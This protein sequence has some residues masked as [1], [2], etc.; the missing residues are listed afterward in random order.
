[1]CVSWASAKRLA[2]SATPARD[3]TGNL[4][5]AM[6]RMGA[7][8]TRRRHDSTDGTLQ[9][10]WKH[11]DGHICLLD[12]RAAPSPHYLVLVCLG[13]WC[14]ASSAVLGFEIGRGCCGFMTTANLLVSPLADQAFLVGG[15][16]RIRRGPGGGPARSARLPRARRRTAWRAAPLDQRGESS[17][18]WVRGEFV[19]TTWFLGGF[20]SSSSEAPTGCG[21]ENKTDQSLNVT[22]RW[23]L[24]AHGIAS[25]GVSGVYVRLAI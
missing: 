3:A 20:D 1:M 16:L 14:P 10:I 6:A 8:Q 22:Q 24:N 9:Y 25:T 15:V 17:P 4:K 18:S 2:K 7:T 19:S 21:T 13:R 11:L 12:P 5:N 23:V